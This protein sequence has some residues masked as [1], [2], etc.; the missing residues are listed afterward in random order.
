MSVLD[1]AIAASMAFVH[2]GLDLSELR[3]NERTFVGLC[4]E[5]WTHWKS[6]G[7]EEQLMMFPT[8]DWIYTVPAP[9]TTRD[10]PLTPEKTFHSKQIT[11]SKSVI[12]NGLKIAAPK[13]W[14]WIKLTD[15]DRAK[16]LLRFER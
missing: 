15:A 7:L 4:F 14:L 16:M 13:G 9:W 1:A 8:R 3:L 5:I 2:E 10:A 11:I 12:E 6:T